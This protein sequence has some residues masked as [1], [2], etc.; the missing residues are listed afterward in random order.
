MSETKFVETAPGIEIAYQ[1]HGVGS[2]VIFLHGITENLTV[3]DQFIPAFSGNYKMVA[4]DLRGHGQSTPVDKASMAELTQDIIVL[5]SKLELGSPAII[6][7]SLGGATGIIFAGASPTG[8]G[9]V[10]C[11]DE[12][13]QMNAFEKVVRGLESE[14]KGP[15]TDFVNALWQEAKD[16]GV[17][18]LPEDL[19]AKIRAFRE[20]ANQDLVLSIW[21]PLF[22]ESVKSLNQQTAHIINNIKTPLLSLHGQD[23]GLEYADW[24]VDHSKGVTDVELWF[25][26]GH[27]LHWA[28]PERFQTSALNFLARTGWGPD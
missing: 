26:E 9:P 5:T 25:R 24:L 7:H 1:V 21:N 11:I 22:T 20:N 6:G 15:R 23:P 16:L 4:V 28:A 8:S 10:L 12:P 17:E 13:M 18:R 3:W 19:Q 27:W 14:L 2:P